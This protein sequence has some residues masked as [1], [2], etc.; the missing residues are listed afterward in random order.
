MSFLKYPEIVW[1]VRVPISGCLVFR[2]ASPEEDSAKAQPVRAVQQTCI[3]TDV[4]PMPLV[5]AP[6]PLAEQSTETER[7]AL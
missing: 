5:L 1:A 7:E 4:L 2:S 6:L 3:E